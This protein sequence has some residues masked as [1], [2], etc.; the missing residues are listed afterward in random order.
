MEPFSL[1]QR[2]G[3]VVRNGLKLCGVGITASFIGV[4]VTNT[5]LWVRA[6]LEPGFQPP[7][8]PQDVLATS[9]AYGAYMA[10]SSNLRCVAPPGPVAAERLLAEAAAAAACGGRQPSPVL[11][12]SPPRTPTCS[13]APPARRYQ[14]LAGVIEE[15]GI[16]TIFKGNYQVT[17]ALSFIVRTANTFLGS[18][19]WVDFVRL[20]GMQKSS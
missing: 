14:L 13:S 12:R 10:T 16:E 4:V 11:H 17:T 15:R 5:L 9:A 20:L 18:L 6:Q 1:G 8:K 3:A 7:N 19:L 2:V